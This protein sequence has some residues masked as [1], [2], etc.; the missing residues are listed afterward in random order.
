[1]HYVPDDFTGVTPKVVVKE[2]E[3]V[4]PDDPCLSTRI[5]LK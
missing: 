2:Q 5:I 4:W 1:M 3:Y